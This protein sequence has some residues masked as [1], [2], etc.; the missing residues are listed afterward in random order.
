MEFKIKY[1][2]IFFELRQKKPPYYKTYLE[3]FEGSPTNV[4][5]KIFLR[6][7]PR[8]PDSKPIY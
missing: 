1:K 3:L 2:A 6:F 4:Q 8:T 7:F 5:I